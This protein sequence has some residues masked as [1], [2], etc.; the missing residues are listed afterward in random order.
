MK[1]GEHPEFYRIAPP[2]GGSRESSIVLDR[3]GHFWHEGEIVENRALEMAMRGWIAIHPDNARLILTN[4]YDWCY[5]RAED[6]PFIVDALRIGE[7]EAAPVFLRL[8]DGSEEEL[9]PQTLCQ[10]EEGIVYARVRKKSLEARFS[11]HAQNELAP[12]L[13]SGDPPTLRIAAKDYTLPA[14]KP[15]Q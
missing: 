8:F 9:D 14:R 11:R 15:S 13:V 5:F 12:L 7:D 4:G 6:A 2:E 3:E 10:N 1:P